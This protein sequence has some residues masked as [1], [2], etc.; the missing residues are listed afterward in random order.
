MNN[1]KTSLSKLE[2]IE[3][4]AGAGGTA[5]GLEQ[6]GFSHLS[7][8]EKDRDSARTLFLNRPNWTILNCDVSEVIYGHGSDDIDLVQAGFPCQPFSQA[9]KKKGLE[10]ERGEPFFEV[11]RCLEETKP[12]LFLLEN[13]PGLLKHE[14]GQTF[15]KVYDLL[16]E[17]GY[18]LQYKVLNALD[19]EVPQKR[20]RL[21][22]VGVRQDLDVTFKFPS[23]IPTRLTLRDALKNVPNSRGS[24]YSTS[25]KY[26]LDHVPPGGNWRDLPEDLQREFMGASL[27]SG[28]GRA[29]MARRLSWDEPSLTILTSPSQKQTE[30]CHPDIT[31]PF[32]IRESAR[33]Q[34]FPDN[35]EFYGSISS[36]YR[37]IGN[38][39][40]P[41]LAYYLGLSLRKSLEAEK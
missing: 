4:F 12:K 35:W 28:G 8:V 1:C 15:Q 9:G 38:A 40:P 17:K 34:T 6:A 21:F 20:H 11:L 37:Q 41:R 14:K 32:T 10:D 29:G 18:N 22:I 19:Y 36:Q 31:R 33:I 25:R 24:S 13:V 2:S 3:L 30:R 16:S 27:Y 26:V 39:V 23:P 7:L 5:L